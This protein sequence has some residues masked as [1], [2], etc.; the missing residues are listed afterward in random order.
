MH[1]EGFITDSGP[2]KLRGGDREELLPCAGSARGRGCR[3]A[4]SRSTADCAVRELLRA[5][6]GRPAGAEARRFAANPTERR[7]GPLI[8]DRHGEC[9]GSLRVDTPAALGA[10]L[11]RTPRGQRQ[12]RIIDFSR[13]KVPGP[14]KKLDRA[15]ASPRLGRW[16]RATPPA[17]CARRATRRGDRR[18]P[19]DQQRMALNTALALGDIAEAHTRTTIA[20]R[21][22]LRTRIASNTPGSY[23]K[24]RKSKFA[25]VGLAYSALHTARN[26]SGSSQLVENVAEH[27]HRRCRLRDDL[28]AD[29]F[30]AKGEAIGCSS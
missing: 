28:S 16:T 6:R 21:G 10:G 15:R 9:G 12:S 19:F 1:S 13:E 5:G 23:L 18:A 26:R 27:R 3:A 22:P 29:M 20:N 2:A 7:S 25:L 4:R 24:R 14:S 11:R 8:S 30:H 17:T